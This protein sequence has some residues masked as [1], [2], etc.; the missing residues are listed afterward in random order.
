MIDQLLK[1]KKVKLSH[2]PK[3][4]ESFFKPYETDSIKP[5][6][7]LVSFVFSLEEM[8]QEIYT[9]FDLLEANGLLYLCYPKLKN[10][11][12]L[13]GIHRDHIFP[14]LEVDEHTG[15]IKHTLMRFNQM[16]SLDHHYTLLVVKK[17]LIRKKR[18]MTSQKAEDYVNDVDH[19]KDILKD[20]TCFSFFNNLTPGYQK[21]WARYIFSAKTIKTKE[22]RIKEMIHLLDQGIKSKDL[23]RKK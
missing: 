1:N 13:L 17:D 22:N 14:F 21:G 18:S 3:N 6:H 11:L 8:K 16:K 19:I 20:K 7:T 5:F 2:I 23:A 4:Y 12:G 9:A 10:G 15:Y